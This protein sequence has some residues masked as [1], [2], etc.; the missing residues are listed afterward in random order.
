MSPSRSCRGV[1]RGKAQSIV[2]MAEH[3]SLL[4]YLQ[5]N[6]TDW[7]N[8]SPGLWGHDSWKAMEG[9]E[10]FVSASLPPY[11]CA[12]AHLQVKD[13][14]SGIVHQSCLPYFHPLP[15]QYPQACPQHFRGWE[16]PQQ[17]SGSGSDQIRCHSQWLCWSGL[18]PVLLVRS[19][20]TLQLPRA[21]MW[22]LQ[23]PGHRT[24]CLRSSSG[25]S[26]PVAALGPGHFRCIQ[27]ALS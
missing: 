16:L 26:C 17:S 22:Q 20:S 3:N 14:T 24:L 8:R 15:G 6:T 27:E 2:Y 12:Q 23:C 25:L 10:K 18:A 13:K 19:R 9:Q 4:E 7:Y 21:G 11:S 1:A 5:S